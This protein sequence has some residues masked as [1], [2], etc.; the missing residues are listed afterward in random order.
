M[1]PKPICLHCSYDIV[2][3]APGNGV[4]TKLAANLSLHCGND[5]C[6]PVDAVILGDLCALMS[7]VSTTTVTTTTVSNSPGT[8]QTAPIVT[9]TRTTST[10][11]M[12]TTGKTDNRESQGRSL[13][14]V[15]FAFGSLGEFIYHFWHDYNL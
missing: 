11:S 3:G 8:T 9:T 10:T 14:R 5:T 2:G 1:L 12:S 15:W 4:W 13:V 7:T 6:W